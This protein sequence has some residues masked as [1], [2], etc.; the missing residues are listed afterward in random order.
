MHINL[1]FADMDCLFPVVRSNTQPLATCGVITNSTLLLTWFAPNITDRCSN[2]LV[3][4]PTLTYTVLYG[5]TMPL[6][7]PVI[8]SH[9]CPIHHVMC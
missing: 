9:T 4:F 3:A 6:D 2:Q 7:N 5:I 1:L 8:K